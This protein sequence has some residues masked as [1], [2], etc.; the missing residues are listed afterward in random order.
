MVG[1]EEG[2]PTLVT[3]RTCESDNDKQ[4]NRGIHFF[5][6]KFQEDS[7]WFLN[8][9]FLAAVPKVN[10]F[11]VTN[12]T[13]SSVVLTWTPVA[14]VSGYLLTWRHISGQADTPI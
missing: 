13:D 7:L 8:F 14:S 2:S 11:T 5:L 10:S 12:T 6:K 1:S 9:L 4:K 3:A